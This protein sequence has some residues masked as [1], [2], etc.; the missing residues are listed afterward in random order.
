M[1]FHLFLSA[2]PDI[3]IRPSAYLQADPIGK[4]ANEGMRIGNNQL[5]I[6]RKRLLSNGFAR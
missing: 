3:F 2:V 6:Q 5:R 4:I 1:S